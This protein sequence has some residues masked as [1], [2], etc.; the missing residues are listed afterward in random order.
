MQPPCSHRGF[1]SFQTARAMFIASKLLS[2]ATQPIAWAM[3]FL[4]LGLLLLRRWPRG[5]RRLCW[6]AF[7]TLALLGWQ[8][9]VE[10]LLRQ[11]ETQYPAPDPQA[12]LSRYV[13]IVVLG[14]ALERSEMWQ[15]PGQVALN[16]AGER[17]IAPIGLLKRNP[18]LRI[19]FTGGEGN[20]N[21]QPLSEAD[22]AKK[23]FDSINIVPDRITYESRSRTTFDNAIFTAELPGV[24]KSQPWLLLTTCAHMPR[25]MGSFVK[26]GWNVTPHCVDY[27]APEH[28]SWSAVTNYSFTLGAEK[29]HYALHEIIGYW[30]YRL[31][32]RI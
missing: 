13:G 10:A 18:N 8:F 15:R 29:W 17:M 27:R 14:G 3:I 19:V 11:L 22:R 9:P 32:G 25:S 12:D 28:A 1:F 20:F 30:A 26:A 16:A 2:F 23:F 6:A 5:A 21:L 31:A 7:A 4:G 24:D